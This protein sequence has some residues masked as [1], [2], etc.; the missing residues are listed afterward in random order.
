MHTRPR[1]RWSMSVATGCTSS[2]RAMPEAGRRSSGSRA[3]MRR[4]WRCITCTRRC[5]ARRARSSLIAPAPGGA[6]QAPSRDAPRPK[7]S[8][9]RPC[10]KRPGRRAPSFWPDTPTED[11]W[12]PTSPA[13]TR[14]A[15]R[16]SCFSTL[17]RPT[18]SS[19]RR[20]TGPR[21]WTG[22]CGTRS[23]RVSTRSSADGPT[24]S[25]RWPKARPRSAR[26]SASS[27]VFWPMWAKPWPPMRGVRRRRSP[28]LPSSR[29]SARG[30]CREPRP[31]SWSTTANS[32]ICQ[33]WW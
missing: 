7:P 8:N 29:S 33:S 14:S 32:A 24:R 26:C 3:A 2:P 31:M 4:V 28:R 1:A 15:R 20:P 25:S 6:I 27:A 9:S 13:D 18:P 11:C 10:W 19:T 30:S 17:H 22:W 12:P 16:L 5:A 23:D 21:P